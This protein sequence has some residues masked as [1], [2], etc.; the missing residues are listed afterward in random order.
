MT[1]EIGTIHSYSL[2]FRSFIHSHSFVFSEVW[3]IGDSNVKHWGDYAIKLGCWHLGQTRHQIVWLGTSSMRWAQFLPSLQLQMITRGHP[4]VII[5]HLGGN[6][7]D[8]VPQFTLMETIWDDLK[9]I[10]SVFQSSLL[11]WC[12]ILPRLLW[13][14]NRDNNSKALNLKCKRINRAAYQYSI[15][16]GESPQSHLLRY[17]T[18]LFGDD[19]VHLSDLRTNIQKFYSYLY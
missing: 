10:H 16:F 2:F 6:N 9:Y 12:G 15:C 4:R 19:G 11:I 1:L 7:V 13:R 17:M 5:I 3:I 14:N 8:S 18:K